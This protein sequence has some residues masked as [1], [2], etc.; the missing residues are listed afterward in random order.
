ML[1][2]AGLRISEALALT[3]DDIDFEVRTITVSKTLTRTN[4]GGRVKVKDMPKTESGNRTVSMV[5]PL[6]NAL[7]DHR[8]NAIASSGAGVL[9]VFP[10]TKGEVLHP[11]SAHGSSLKPLREKAGMPWLKFHGLRH[12]AASL[13]LASGVPIEATS[14]QHGHKNIA[15]TLDLYSHLTIELTQAIADK[16]DAML[17]RRNFGA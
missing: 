1:G 15:I 12:A 8:Q 11:S 5:K 7:F 6:W 17:E 14:K 4:R 10:S 2:F 3:W 9:L 13:M 16:V